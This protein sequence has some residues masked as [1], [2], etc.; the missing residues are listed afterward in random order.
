VVA[1]DVPRGDGR[2]GSLREQD[3]VAE[4]AGE[5]KD[6]ADVSR[7]SQLAFSDDGASSCKSSSE[8]PDDSESG[9]E[10]SVE[11]ARRL[12]LRGD[13]NAETSDRGQT[14]F[15]SKSVAAPCL[16]A[17]MGLKRF[18]GVT[19]KD[20][21]TL[22]S[23]Q[24]LLYEVLPHDANRKCFLSCLSTRGHSLSSLPSLPLVYSSPLLPF[25]RLFV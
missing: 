15:M 8:S 20:V 19:A 10:K 23:W 2:D 4:E 5:G 6:S 9:G 18:L 11:D 16:V 17:V 21:T 12:Q 25:R 7:T 22:E 1:T 14:Y 3:S 24:E 13:K